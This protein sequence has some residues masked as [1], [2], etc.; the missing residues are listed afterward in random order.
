MAEKS[1]L[2][3]IKL[4]ISRNFKL[5]PYERIAFHK[6]LGV[7]KSEIGMNILVKELDKG[8]DVRESA[9]AT[10]VNFDNPQILATILPY[11]GD[12][13]SGAEKKNILDHI[14]RFGHTG[15]ITDI[16]VFIEKEKEGLLTETSQETLDILAHAFSVL[17]KK[18]EESDELLTYLRSIIFSD[19]SEPVIVSLAIMTLSAFRNIRVF[20]ELL[21]RNDDL[22]TASVYNALYDLY[23]RVAD[24]AALKEKDEEDYY[25]YS[26]R[27]E[28]EILLDIRVLLG[29]KTQNFDSYTNRTKVAFINAMVCCNHREYLIYTMKA[30]TSS[31]PDLINSTLYS[32]YVNVNRLRD[33]DKL[34]RSLISLATELDKDNE[35]I[36]DMFVKYFSIQR[37]SREFHILQDKLYG[38]I[39]VTL[40]AYFETYRKEFMITEVIEKGFPEGFQ[41]IR[42]FILERMTPEMKKKIV[43]FLNLDDSREINHILSDLS[44]WVAYVGEDEKADL[45]FLIEIFL[46]SDKKS[47]ENSAL[48]I[49]DIKFEKRYLRNRIIRLCK[50]IGRLNITGASSPLVNIYNFI[51]KYPDKEIMDITIH[52]LSMLNY[53]YM[54]GEIEITLTTGTEAEKITSLE[55]ISL[56]SEQRSLNILFE[57]I[58]SKLDEETEIILLAVNILLE[59]DITGNVTANE[60]FKRL[61]ETNNNSGIRNAAT[62][63]IGKS[64]NEGDIE[65]LHNLFLSTD[66]GVEKDIIVRAI[67]YIVTNISDYNKR[68]L[69]KYLQEYLKD[70]GIMVRIYSCLL[71][72]RLGNTDAL[73]SIRDMLIIKNKTIQ[74]DILTILGDLKSVEF[75]FFL[76]S[77]LKE[78]YG[79][80]RDIIHILKMLPEEA[81]KEIDGFIVN[82]FRKYEAPDMESSTAQ[83]EQ[84]IIL[85]GLVQQ[86]TTILNID[87]LEFD[88]VSANRS[89]PE[90]IKLNIGIKSFVSSCI[91]ECSGVI[92]KLSNSKVVAFF[93]DPLMA[94][95][96]A[97]TISKNMEDYNRSRQ[98]S[99]RLKI[100]IQVLTETVKLVNDELIRFREYSIEEL[101]ALPLANRIVID[102][103]T[104]ER[105]REN[106]SVKSIP[107]LIF[108]MDLSSKKYYELLSP[109]N[110]VILS[111]SII[112][113]I[114]LENE[115]KVR[116]ETELEDELKK[117]KVKDRSKSSISIATELDDIG[118]KLKNQFDDIE[119]YVQRRSTDREL[120]RSLHKMLE[121]SY[122]SY[123]VEISR[124]V[125]K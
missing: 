83:G 15:N 40:E 86:E 116:K 80:S 6:I 4:E 10:L 68:Q 63:G 37:S 70:P 56:F 74:R 104:V 75:S 38:Y 8:P 66:S 78:E 50:I 65:Y 82:I 64:G 71:L 47:R 102:S 87:V 84:V 58:Q 112:E 7:L 62:L 111:Q 24:S 94:A 2:Q 22:I 103:G 109:V 27:E 17:S 5:T 105:I 48:R 60:I 45:A 107:E 3:T 39:V 29:K 52:T 18:G 88:R 106:F 19:D 120:I 12:T 79:I 85:E 121:N 72:V 96:T 61:V 43:N 51:K 54:L 23:K 114:V 26:Q 92:T 67:E 69:M 73:R 110:F 16:I 20:E 44:K 123:K 46:D 90:L 81:L 99:G 55:L 21:N 122:N 30:L 36:V 11:L 59:K 53:S 49:E 97:L 42:K 77:L 31:D 91:Y 100:S 117:L 125:I 124:I 93:T 113:K 57:F 95:Q 76:V 34:F 41:K 118:Q 32:L 115:E 14:E 9:I 1:F 33:P 35:L 101:Q 98:L 119:R 13:I 28:D 108:P 25:T 89:I